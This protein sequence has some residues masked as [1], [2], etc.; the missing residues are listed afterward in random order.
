[1]LLWSGNWTFRFFPSLLKLRFFLRRLSSEENSHQRSTKCRLPEHKSVAE[2]WVGLFVRGLM[3][4][5]VPTLFPTDAYFI[6]FYG[7]LPET[8]EEELKGVR[9][10]SFA[11]ASLWMMRCSAQVIAMQVYAVAGFRRLRAAS[12]LLSVC[13]PE[14]HGRGR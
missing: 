10:A 11:A 7:Y 12:P 14:P 4:A 13:S 9:S 2:L 8:T 5:G 6:T 1:M 3:P